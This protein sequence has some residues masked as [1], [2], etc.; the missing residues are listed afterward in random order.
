[1]KLYFLRHAHAHDNAD[2]AMP[3]QQRPLTPRGIEQAHAVA[4]LLQAA[5]VKLAR[6][7]S[8]PLVRAR[9]TAEIAGQAL[10][11]A[12]QVR[13]EVGPG[14]SPAV[15]AA[16]CRELGPDDAAMFVGHEPD[17]SHTVSSL[18][19]GGHVV[20]KKSGLARVDVW[21]FQPPAGELVWLIAP[22]VVGAADD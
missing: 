8:S 14:F 7:Y 10:G 13:P 12:V 18:I 22:R 17:F 6:L 9:Q 3:D 21:Q 4:R 1:M 2:G 5:E 16:L 11:V 15:V 19:G 20:M